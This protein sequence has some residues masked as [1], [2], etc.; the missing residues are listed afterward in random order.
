MIR[1]GEPTTVFLMGV[2]LIAAAGCLGPG[3]VLG[4][5]TDNEDPIFVG[6]ISVTTMTVGPHPDPDGYVVS[7]DEARTLPIETNGTVSFE[8][9]PVGTYGIRL[10]GFAANCSVTTANPIF[11]TLQVDSMLATHFEVACPEVP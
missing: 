6:T 3:G 1:Y 10:D 8:G 5:D 9:I 2:A 11:V 4:N 7:L